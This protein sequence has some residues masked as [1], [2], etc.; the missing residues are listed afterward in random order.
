MRMWMIDPR[1]MCRKHLLG[2]HV[3]CH[4]FLGTIRKGTSIKGYLEK[5]LLETHNL[6]KRHDDL[7]EEMTRRGYNHKTLLE[8]YLPESGFINVEHNEKDLKSRCSDCF[9]RISNGN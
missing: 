7:A 1:K 6:K 5:G 2:E 9:E 3:E 4:M 8:C